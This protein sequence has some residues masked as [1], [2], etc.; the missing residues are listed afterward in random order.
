MSNNSIG[1]VDIEFAMKNINF[2][3]ETEKMKAGIR[4]V[5][6]TAQKEATETGNF[7]KNAFN[8]IGFTSLLGAGGAMAAAFKFKQLAQEAFEFENAFGMAMRE[9]QTISTA[10]KEDFEGI[11]KAIV[12]LSANSPD[13]AIKLAKAYYQIVSAGHDGAAGLELLTIASKAAVAGVTD[14]MT[15]A[16][17]LTTVINAWGLSAN[18]ANNVADAM[19]KT[20]ERG[21][22]TFAQ[23]AANIAQVAPLASA[24]GIGLNEIFAALQTITKQGTPT[25]QAM[26]Q[27]RSSIINL[28][29]ALGDGWSNTMTYQEAL[30]L[31]SEKAG[32]SATAL[33]KLIPDVEGMSAVL[34][35]T[36]EK[37]QGAADDLN[38]TAK[39]AGSMET[40]Y[41]S[42]MEEA[43]NKWSVIHNKW[44][45]EIRE[46]GKAMKDESTNI[47]NFMDALLTNGSDV[48]TDLSIY[49]IADKIK[50]LRMMGE[51]KISAYLK[52][53]LM[54][55]NAVREQYAQYIKTIQDYAAQGL[56]AQQ[57]KLGDILGLTD[58]DERLTELN[59][60]LVSMKEAEQDLGA[61]TFINNQQQQAALKIRAELWGEIEAKAKEAVKV[62]NDEGGGGGGIE[63][64]VRN[65]KAM[66]EEL[67]ATTEKFGAGS[68]DDDI[69]NLA[70]QA[71]LNQE[72]KA[73][74]DKIREERK[75]ATVQK[76]QPIGAK[77][78]LGGVQAITKEQ[79][80]QEFQGEKLLKQ[81]KAKTAEAQKQAAAIKEQ[82]DKY[83]FQTALFEGLSNGLGDTAEIMGALSYAIGE[84]DT[85]LGQSVGRMADLAGNASTMIAN[86]AAGGNPITS[87][88]SGINTIGSIIGLV[89][90]GNE[91][92]NQVS[93]LERMNNLLKQQS[94]ILSNLAGSNYFQLAEKQY[95]DYGRAILETNEKLR[96]SG[97]LTKAEYLKILEV[98]DK[99][100][101]TQQFK[102]TFGNIS[103]AKY[104]E[105]FTAATTK[106][107]TPEQFVEAFA[108]GSLVLDQQQIE[109][110]TEI[111]EKQKQR[112]ELLQETFRQ[113]LGFDA[114]TVSDSIVNGIESGLKLGANSLGTFA[115][116]FGELVEKALMQS[117]IDGMNLQLTNGFMTNFNKFMNDGDGLTDTE[118]LT[119]EA[120]YVEA[121]RQGQLKIEAIQPIL[122]KYGA[123]ISANAT[124]LTGISKTATED[125]MSAMVGQLMAVRVDIK[126][127]IKGMATGQD[128]VTKNLFYLKEIA[129]NTSHNKELLVIRDEMKEMNRTL[130]DRL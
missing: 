127:I 64:K 106:N 12:D 28:N 99:T 66:L 76:L 46:L 105:T 16:D 110:V 109:W 116:S 58:K 37:A 22:T 82:N 43:N 56:S 77:E 78:T 35:M 128:D 55:E 54:P 114:S 39:A 38:E 104:L 84:F 26:T 87:I 102:Q 3:A 61:T 13:D 117:I 97:V 120:D 2:Q 103:F 25:A 98:Y 80:K 8:G 36:G 53:G 121:V 86:F 42:M 21:K 72:I 124:G 85:T 57:I 7:L 75:A 73:Y 70:K 30:N 130:K 89:K 31:I 20:V 50:A 40:A 65:L 74:Y 92:N 125:T 71:V 11:S 95:K 118:R 83:T 129:Q 94:A 9:V 108:K 44:T 90:S 49:G 69:K 88:V 27:I 32:G 112:A 115:E 10:V 48:K 111:T 62:I 29:N 59:G 101:Q 41:N 52:G 113:A 51:G 126:E 4:G 122:D 93:T 81:S 63:G 14:T 1:P 100:S 33:K 6:L 47:A 107:W 34:A 23:L 19:F 45:R 67:K 119:L 68:F 15:A 24:N 91:P 79:T 123:A 60:F 96:L 5:T 18:Q 17:G